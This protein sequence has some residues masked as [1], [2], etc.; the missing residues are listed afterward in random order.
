MLRKHRARLAW[1]VLFS[2]L[3]LVLASC[4]KD[5]K[6]KNEYSRNKMIFLTAVIEAYKV[7]KGTTPSSLEEIR[8]YAMDYLA[9]HSDLGRDYLDDSWSDQRLTLFAGG[10]G[11][12]VKYVR[13]DSND[14]Y[15]YYFDYDRENKSLTLEALQETEQLVQAEKIH[16]ISTLL[17]LVHNG[18]LVWP[19]YRHAADSVRRVH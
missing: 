1:Y 11:G 3:S 12:S 6:Y 8:P 7:A 17:F 15:L 4:V 14:Y 16:G 5:S 19:G 18:D 10:T 13:G 2:V 9:S